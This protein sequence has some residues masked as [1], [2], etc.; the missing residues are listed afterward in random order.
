MLKGI[1][2]YVYNDKALEVILILCP[3]RI[4]VVGSRLNNAAKYGFQ[5]V[6]LNFK[7]N[8]KVFDSSHDICINIVRMDLSCQAS[9]YCR[10]Y[11]SQLDNEETHLE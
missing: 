4:M 5:L 6:K 9:H 11:N 2:T 1:L 10:F 8:Q 3:F 7:Y